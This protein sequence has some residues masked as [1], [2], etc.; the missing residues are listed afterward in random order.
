MLKFKYVFS[1]FCMLVAM[2]MATSAIAQ[3]ILLVSSGVEPRAREHGYNEEAGGIT[4]RVSSGDEN[5]A[6]RGTLTIDY[7]V[8]VT[9]HGDNTYDDGA[10]VE[11]NGIRVTLNG[12]GITCFGDRDDDDADI[13][14]STVTIAIAG[15]DSCTR[16]ASLD[17]S[18]VLLAM[19]N[20]GLT[21]NVEASISVDN[22]FRLSSG[23][24]RVTVINAVVDELTD[25]G[26]TTGKDG[27]ITIIRHTGETLAGTDGPFHLH[28]D[29]NAV[30]S[31]ERAELNLAFDGIPAG[32]TIKLDAWVYNKLKSDGKP[33][34]PNTDDR[35]MYKAQVGVEN[36]D[37]YVPAVSVD[38]NQE[39]AMFPSSV[40]STTSNTV[41]SMRLIDEDGDDIVFDNDGPTV[42]V[43]DVTTGDM[44]ASTYVGGMLSST[45]VDRITIRGYITFDEDEGATLPLST[46]EVT[47]TAD[48][49]P[50]GVLKPS[51]TR[52]PD[53]PR[54]SSDPTSP[55]SVI[56]VTSDQTTLSLPYALATMGFDTGIAI[57]NM[58]TKSEQAG[59]ITFMLYQNGDEA[60]RVHHRRR[61][62]RHGPDQRSTGGRHDVCGP[63][64]RTFWMPLGWKV[65]SWATR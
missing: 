59:A 3:N 56:G 49:G 22:D 64:D 42:T 47:V 25:G 13:E 54:F 51:G 1:A 11:G 14:G 18:G 32:A 5:M 24:N 31:F 33:N 60:G 57:S 58:N 52:A 27:D 50:T 12:T 35:V 62:S 46:F 55:V 48:V 2:T 44:T 19:A 53:I 30:D 39:V 38:G 4:L 41:V 21:G 36:D 16:D 6:P 29:E 28:I 43:E 23:G 26:V 40:T 63:A 8:P 7:G 65:V 45:K 17:V 10:F 9:N 20:S 37:D 34:T 61:L 15:T